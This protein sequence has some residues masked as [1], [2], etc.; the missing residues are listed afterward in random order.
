MKLTAFFPCYNDRPTIGRLVEEAYTTI[1]RLGYRPEVIVI[2]DGSTDGSRELLKKLKQTKHPDLRLVFHAAN[3]GYGAVLADGLAHATG[4]LIFYT[5]GDGQYDVGELPHLVAL[6]DADT[7]CVNGIKEE[8]R[9]PLSRIV[10]GNAYKF[11][12]RWLFWLPIIDV[13][14]DFRL[15]RRAIAKKIH[16][17]TTSGA[18]CIELVKKAEAAGAVFREV[19]VSHYPRRFGNSQFFTL[20]RLTHTL[21]EFARLWIAL[22]IMRPVSDARETAPPIR[23][24][25]GE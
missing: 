13:D 24:I 2:D 10:L 16:L 23:K 15:I 5:D 1:K 20:G 22:M 14:C 9:D 21:V 3:Q 7:S 17:T 19:T 4:D 18:V 12:A 25:L 8:R 11:L 6:M